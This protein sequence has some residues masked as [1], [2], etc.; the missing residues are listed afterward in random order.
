M[1]FRFHGKSGQE[2]EI[3]LLDAKVAKIVKRSQHLPGEA[4][5]EYRSE[6]CEYAPVDSGDVNEYL[7]DIAGQDV[8]AKDFRT[9]HGSACAMRELTK[10]GPAPDETP[11]S[12]ISSLSLNSP[13]SCWGNRSSNLSQIL[14]S[15][16]PHPVLRGWLPI[17]SA[18]AIAFQ[19]AHS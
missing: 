1:R 8:T 12:A 18:A 17:R 16:E 7:R 10:L 19:P 15:S 2:H 6:A 11:Q 9:W 14:H 5:F 13:P 3:E 4:L